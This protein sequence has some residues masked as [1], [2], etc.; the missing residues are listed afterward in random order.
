MRKKIFATAR[1]RSHDLLQIAELL[2]G[3]KVLLFKSK[4]KMPN[5]VNI[6]FSSRNHSAIWS[7]V[8][9]FKRFTGC[10]CMK[11]AFSVFFSTSLKKFYMTTANVF[12]S[13]W[14]FFGKNSITDYKVLQSFSF[15]QMV[16]IL[17]F[18]NENYVGQNRSTFLK[19]PLRQ[20]S[21][22][23]FLTEGLKSP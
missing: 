17:I 13:C 11:M 20:S 15:V 3:Q 23:L 9:I 4:C 19:I 10:Q 2:V 21:R 16:Q 18:L 8:H 14:I 6:L 7:K 5:I 22:F 12:K 1:I